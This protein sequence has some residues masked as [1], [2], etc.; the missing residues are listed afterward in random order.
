[1]IR[2]I[3]IIVTLAITLGHGTNIHDTNNGDKYIK[4]TTA[5]VCQDS[6]DSIGKN[7]IVDRAKEVKC[8]DMLDRYKL[9]WKCDYPVT[10]CEVSEL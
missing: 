10:I 4:E 9:S 3:L 7:G 2:F 8:A 6:L 1:M 5:R